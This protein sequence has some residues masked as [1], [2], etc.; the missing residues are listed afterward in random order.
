MKTLSL[1]LVRIPP[2]IPSRTSCVFENKGRNILPAW[3]YY[4]RRECVCERVRG[5]GRER[6]TPDEAPI[7]ASPNSLADAKLS[8][9]ERRV[10][11]IATLQLRKLFSPGSTSAAICAKLAASVSHKQTPESFLRRICREMPWRCRGDAVEMPWRCSA[12]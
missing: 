1:T 8:Q 11:Q 3:C 9:G 10:R 7:D 5:G 4:A 2:E 12:F 6:Q